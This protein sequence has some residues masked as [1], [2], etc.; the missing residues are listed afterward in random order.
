[1]YWYYFF[2]CVAVEEGNFVGCQDKNDKHSFFYTQVS[3]VDQ[4][5]TAGSENK[6]K[7]HWPLLCTQKGAA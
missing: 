2:Y 3:T 7:N 4:D 6:K 1:M 5:A